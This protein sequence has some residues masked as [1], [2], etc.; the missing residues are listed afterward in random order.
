MRSLNKKKQIK[1]NKIRG[2]NNCPFFYSPKGVSHD[3][4]KW[5]HLEGVGDCF[6]S[7]HL[8]YGFE[9]ITIW[10]RS[11]MYLKKDYG[12]VPDAR[13][14]LN[15]R[16]VFIEYDRG[17]M[18]KNQILEKIKNYLVYRE[19]NPE[20]LF[21]VVFV[22]DNYVLDNKIKKKEKTRKDWFIRLLKENRTAI[23]MPYL[24]FACTMGELSALHLTGEKILVNFLDENLSFTD[25]HQYVKA[26][27]LKD[28]F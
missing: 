25:L 27:K 19:V 21:Y 15:Y 7:L 9:D 24:F 3:F 23:K 14:T 4:K 12:I 16:L 26:P 22:F 11:P 8:A 6:I 18:T 20:V 1:A 17:S 28:S 5:E 13:M 10:E 2:N